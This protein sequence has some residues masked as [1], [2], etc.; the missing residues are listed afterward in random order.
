M[1][2]RAES[3]GWL[4]N[5]MRVLIVDDHDLFRDGIASLLS[6]RGYVVVGEASD[7]LESAE[8]AEVRRVLRPHLRRRQRRSPHIP[9]DGVEDARRAVPPE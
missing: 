6:A 9:Q 8:E 5:N 1:E 3:G 4:T 7:G 2:E